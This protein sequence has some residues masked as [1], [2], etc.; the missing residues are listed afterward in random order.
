[1]RVLVTGGRTFERRKLLESVL[2]GIA[3]EVGGELQIVTGG[4]KGADSMAER[5]AKARGMPCSVYPADWGQ[6]G[7]RAGPIRN[8]QM[9]DEGKPDLVL[10]FPGG[11][12]TSD[13]VR[14]AKKAGV[15]VRLAPGAF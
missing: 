13:M 9:L 10:A 5:W 2:D 11:P 1:M 8:R 7:R 14:L 12:G 4:A 15:P 6:F 3:R